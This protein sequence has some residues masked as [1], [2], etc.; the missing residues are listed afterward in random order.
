MNKTLLRQKRINR[1]QK[2]EHTASCRTCGIKFK[3][4]STHKVYCST[5]CRIEGEAKDN[6]RIHMCTCLTCGT[7]F[8]AVSD[9]IKYCSE[10]CDKSKRKTQSKLSVIEVARRAKDEGMSYGEYVAK[11]NI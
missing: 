3:P 5:E 4:D 8:K 11:Y 6:R 9:N 1:D 2:K 7:I 10:Q